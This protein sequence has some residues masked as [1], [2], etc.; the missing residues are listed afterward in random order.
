MI[1][2]SVIILNWKTREDL[3]RCLHSIF[4][5][6]PS[7][8]PVGS[9]RREARGV[10]VP[11]AHE[12]RPPEMEVIVVDN[13]STDGSP[14][15]VREQFPQARLI[16]NPDNVGFS[17]GNNRGIEASEGRY[18]LLLNPDTITQPGAFAALV[19]F[20]DAHPEAG[21]VGA[22][23]LNGDGSLQYSCR[24]FPTL[25]TG[26]FRDTPLGR[27]F[28]NNRY[29]RNYLLT[30]WDHNSPREI[31]WVSGAAMLIRREVLE[32]IGNL[33]EDFFM[34]CEDV[35]LC[36]RARQRGWKTLFCPDAV[37]T[38][39]IARASDQ[40]AGAMLKERHRSMYLFFRKH[41]AA[42]AHPLVWPLVVG[43]LAARASGLVLKN[44]V[45][46]WRQAR[47]ARRRNKIEGAPPPAKG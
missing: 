41:Y 15:M 34:Y 26:F 10:A 7:L 37:F 29:N 38:H 3:R 27:L 40:N 47:Q 24:A 35:D 36:Y 22:K 17:A 31:E 9:S 13:A 2:L 11:A 39:L 12:G 14:E 19:A 16:V 32:Q 30:D 45:D 18:V 20:A 43:G 33:D 8:V 5:S 42:T 44:K 1:D 6:Q 25:A 46:R 23:L 4:Q 28:P 21:V